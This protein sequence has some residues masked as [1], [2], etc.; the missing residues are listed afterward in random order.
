[1]KIV[2]WNTAWATSS[3]NRGKEIKARISE[4]NPDIVCLTETY[5]DF[6]TDAGYSIES[7]SDYGYKANPGRRKVIVWSRQPWDKADVIGDETL[8][9]GRFASGITKVDDIEIVIVGI[10]IPWKDAHVRTGRM[11]MQPWQDH[12][13][14]IRGLN[15]YLSDKKGAHIIVIG[16]FNQ[17]IPRKSAPEEMYRLLEDTFRDMHIVTFGP[18]KP[19]NKQTIDHVVTSR[20]V[21]TRM[22]SSISNISKSGNILSDHFGIFTECCIVD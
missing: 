7:L 5:S 20:N 12:E 14:Y 3:S 15:N 9:G 22:I 10:C 16:D 4:L 17:L 19:V 21:I 8:P 18:I 2:N 6:I 13:N 11:D 1:M